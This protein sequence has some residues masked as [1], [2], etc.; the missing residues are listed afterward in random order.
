MA[1]VKWKTPSWRASPLI[2][3][4]GESVRPLEGGHGDSPVRRGGREIGDQPGGVV[5]LESR[6]SARRWSRC[7]RWREGD[8]WVGEAGCGAGNNS[9]RGGGARRV[10]V[11]AAELVCDVEVVGVVDVQALSDSSAARRLPEIVNA[12]AMFPNGGP[13]AN[14]VTDS[15]ER[16]RGQNAPGG[17]LG[18][19]DRIVERRREASE[20]P[21]GTA[22]PLA[23]G[24]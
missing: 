1:T 13:G 23:P 15:T 8:R 20:E 12:G 22:S 11:D 24:A 5:T 4:A 21:T 3:P 17:I 18:K 7:Q 9:E 14:A 10:D 2:C 6:P 19:G 16:V